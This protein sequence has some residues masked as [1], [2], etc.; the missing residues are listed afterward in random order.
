M[1]SVLVSNRKQNLRFEHSGGPLEFGRGPRRDVERFVLNDVFASR[2]QV[3]VEELPNK[4]LRVDN[5]SLKQELLLSDERR[6][7]PGGHQEFTLPVRF[8]AGQS[9]LEFEWVPVDAF[10]RASLLTIE[11]PAEPP[12]DASRA[13]ATLDDLGETPTPAALVRWFESAIRAQQQATNSAEFYAQIAR[14]LVE[15]VGLDL[16]MVLLRRDWTWEVVARHAADQA[17]SA[18]FSPALLSHVIAERRTFYQDMTKAAP[19]VRGLGLALQGVDAVVVAPVFGLGEHMVGALYGLRNPRFPA[20]GG[21]ITELEAQCV[22]L[23]A[24]TLGSHLGR[25]Q[26]ARTRLA[27]EQSFAPRIVRE[28]EREPALLEGRTQEVSL[29]VSGAEDFAALVEHMGPENAY[30]L[31]RELLERQAD[32]VIQASGVIAEYGEAGLVALWNAPVRQHD[33]ATL[34]SGAALAFLTELP[35]LS[36][37]WQE[38]LGLPLVVNF[39][40]HTGAAQAGSLGSSQH[41]KYGV[42]GPAVRLAWQLHRLA[43]KL[44]LPLILS[45]P[46]CEELPKSFAVRRLGRVR[47]AGEPAPVVLYELHGASAAPEWIA[48]RDAYEDALA[49]FEAGKWT[50]ACQ[51]LGPLTDPSA[52]PDLATINLMRQ[53]WQC[54]ASTP[55]T[56]D[57][58]LDLA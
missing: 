5:L 25:A 34:A 17:C 11:A 6:V 2:D 41:F 14:T 54:R 55:A 50:E 33:H 40:L 52:A 23:L 13:A 57:A 35:E 58:V 18:Q 32:K 36:S 16:G 19:P 20:R 43:Q 9:L 56:F 22:Q 44:R 39:G 7:P 45:G 30:R 1:I 26:V 31:A 15:L 49:L 47:L 38:R 24:H 28:I 42:T 53:A 29:L 48:F 3:R 21:R 51:A 46:A 12:T 10:D 27:Y 37:R 4:R 8:K